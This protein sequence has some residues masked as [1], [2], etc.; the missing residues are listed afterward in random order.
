MSLLNHENVTKRKMASAVTRVAAGFIALSLTFN[1]SFAQEAEEPQI[2]QTPD[3][4]F[5]V[6]T[7]DA[8]GK[9]VVQPLEPVQ[10]QEAQAPAPAAAPAAIESAPAPAAAMVQ[11]TN[12]TGT[13]PSVQNIQNIQVPAGTNIKIT[14][15]G[16]GAGVEIQTTISPAT[17][18]VQTAAEP[19]KKVPVVAA[20]EMSVASKNERVSLWQNGG[21]GLAVEGVYYSLDSD[22]AWQEGIEDYA[23]GLG[24]H[25]EY[26]IPKSTLFFGV[27]F[28]IIGYDDNEPIYVD[29]YDGDWYYTSDESAASAVSGFAEVGQKFGFFNDAIYLG[30]RAGYEEIFYSKRTIDWCNYCREEDIEINGGPYVGAGLGIRLVDFR[31]GGGMYLELDYRG[32]TT[33]DI[34][35]ASGIQLSWML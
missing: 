23:G 27:G 31:R 33:G 29:S 26:Y 3:G 5:F 13:P 9:T 24:F 12:E 15:S 6:V 10:T 30:L 16:Q 17:T 1:Y 4:K 28:N 34:E 19:A 20:T 8:E 25:L 22:V 21:I 2:L 14:P 7:K 35:S 11:S 32:Y 18:E